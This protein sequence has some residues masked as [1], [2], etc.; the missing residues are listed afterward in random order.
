MSGC[1]TRRSPLQ[2]RAGSMSSP[3][4]AAPVDGP[5][6]SPAPPARRAVLK[7][8]VRPAAALVLV[9]LVAVSCATTSAMRK[10]RDAEQAQD[11]DRAVVQYTL[12]LKENPDNVDARASLE[13][14]KLR[15]SRVPLQQRPAACR[16]RQAR[17]GAARVPDRRRDE[18]VQQRGG[19]GAAPDPQPAARE[20]GG[21]ARGQDRARDAH[22]ADA[23]RAAAR[24][25]TSRPGSSCRPRSCSARRA[26]ATSTRRSRASPT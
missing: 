15:A 21:R 11:Y 6:E 14:A 26:A 17:G 8:A 19:Q 9:A 3:M 16:G 7:A 4:A 18:P 13:R 5:A 20:S 12:A 10:G 24:A 23:G 1:L 22:R 25:S 2:S